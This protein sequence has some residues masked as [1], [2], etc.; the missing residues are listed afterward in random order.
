MRLGTFAP[1]LACLILSGCNR[2]D[3]QPKQQKEETS[4][5]AASKTIDV[6]STAFEH[7]Q[8]IPQQYAFAPEGRNVTPAV[9]WSNLPD[10]TQS[11]ALIVD[12]PDAP[13]EDPW[14]H[15][16]QYNIPP[17]STGIPEGGANIG[18]KGRNDFDQ[19]GWGG[20]LPPRG[21]GTHHYRFKVYALNAELNL[22][23]GAT[24]EEVVKAMEGHVLAQGELV[25]T[26]EREAQ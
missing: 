1:F 25:G 17:D 22:P 13:K 5:M 11:V 16:V 6:S 20:P 23:T 14:V 19:T 8:P 7:N 24:K 9:S 21:H 10:G 3:A 26:Y 15:W 18:M 4:P 2:T 12:D